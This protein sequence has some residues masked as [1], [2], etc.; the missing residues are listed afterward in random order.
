M[1]SDF[2]LFPQAVKTA[3]IQSLLKTTMNGYQTSCFK[4]NHIKKLF[5]FLAIQLFWRLP[6]M[7]FC[8]S[9][10]PPA[11]SWKNNQ[12]LKLY[13]WLDQDILM[14]V[15]EEFEVLCK[16]HGLCKSGHDKNNNRNN[17]LTSK[18]I[19]WKKPTTPSVWQPSVLLGLSAAFDTVD[20][21][22]LYVMSFFDG[23]VLNWYWILLKGQGLLCVFR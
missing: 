8:D 17:I 19:A 18:W 12:E 1:A 22:I 10:I 4:F 20:H 6:V 16:I 14:D 15:G 23:L 2:R 11:Q 3:V 9:P 21:N 13:T 7:R 5:F